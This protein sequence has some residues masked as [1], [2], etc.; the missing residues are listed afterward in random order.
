MTTAKA[1][2]NANASAP[3]NSCHES[4]SHTKTKATA[5]AIVA[6]VTFLVGVHFCQST[7]SAFFSGFSA[8]FGFAFGFGAGARTPRRLCQLVSSDGIRIHTFGPRHTDSR[9]EQ[10]IISSHEFHICSRHGH[11]RTLARLETVLIV[12]NSGHG[13]RSI[14]VLSGYQSPAQEIGGE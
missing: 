1:E 8:F 2:P 14:V 13:S 9:S 5:A 10:S 7:Y 6:A 4:N 11:R 12:L 3:V